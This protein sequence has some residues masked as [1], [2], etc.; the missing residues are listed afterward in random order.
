MSNNSDVSCVNLTNSEISSM[1]YLAEWHDKIAQ[2]WVDEYF[3]GKLNYCDE[4]QSVYDGA[5]QI[6]FTVAV[7][8]SK[9]ILPVNIDENHIVGAFDEPVIVGNIK[10]AVVFE[11]IFNIAKRWQALRADEK[12]TFQ[13]C[14]FVPRTYIIDIEGQ[15]VDIA[16]ASINKF[17]YD[18]WVDLGVTPADVSSAKLYDGLEIDMPDEAIF[19]QD[20]DMWEL[21]GPKFDSGFSDVIIYDEDYRQVWASDLDKKNLDQQGIRFVLEDVFNIDEFTNVNHYVVM[22]QGQFGKFF[23]GE[24]NL[25]D[26]FDPRKLSFNYATYNGEEYIKMV[27]YE[28]KKI[29]CLENNSLCGNYDFQFHEK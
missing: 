29:D 17:Q 27:F 25:K 26:N 5:S 13:T 23:T 8:G 9:V 10:L 1:D 2:Q 18:Y 22:T 6:K 3:L 24:I 21:T 15:A 14:K 19:Q 20:G 7:E 4:V 11:A 16:I 28:G 12:K